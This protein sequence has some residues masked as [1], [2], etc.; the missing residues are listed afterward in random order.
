MLDIPDESIH[1]TVSSP[2]YNVGM[3]YETKTELN[4]YLGFVEKVLS[5]VYRVTVKGGR[6]VINIANTGRNPYIP[7]TTYYTN[8]M[9][10]LGFL[11]RGVIIW[12]KGASA[13]KKTSWGSWMSSTNPS[14]RDVNE[15]ILC[16]SKGGMARE[17]SGESDL[18]RDEFLCYTESIWRIHAESALKIGHPAPYP[19]ELPYRAIKLYSFKGDTVLDPFMG[20]GTTAVASLKCGRHYVGYELNSKYIR[21]A[22]KRIQEFH[23]NN[24]DMFEYNGR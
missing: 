24:F 10:G 23:D 3:V 18:T 17:D 13:G 11:H 9:E 14:L 4:I 19:V 22:N 1:L 15:F 12:D 6:V 20:S 8:I 21:I 7:L 2:P 16:F 5:E